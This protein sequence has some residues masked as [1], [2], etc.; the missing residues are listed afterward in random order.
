MTRWQW[1]KQSRHIWRQR[2]R[3]HI[4]VHCSWRARNCIWGTYTATT[5]KV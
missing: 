2:R 4:V 3:D 5:P 1:E